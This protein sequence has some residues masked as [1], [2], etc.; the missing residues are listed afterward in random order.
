MATAPGLDVLQLKRSKQTKYY[1]HIFHAIADLMNYRLFS[2]DYYDGILCDG[3]F[4]IP[5][6]R[7]LEKK[8]NLKKKDLI[9]V[10]CC[11]MD[12]LKTRLKTLQI[13]KENFSILIAPTWG[14]DS[15]L[16]KFGSKLIDNLLNEN[17]NIIIRPHPQSLKVE[18]KLID[19]LVLK[20]KN[21]KNIAWD[22]EID[23]LPTMAK[24]DILISDF[25]GII[26]DW[27]F[28]FEKPFLYSMQEINDEI[29]DYSDLDDFS[30]RKNLIKSLGKE[31]DNNSI[32]N[33]ASLIKNLNQD[34]DFQNKIQ[35][36]KKI[37][38]EKQGE[39]AKNIVD[40]IVQKQK[41]LS[42]DSI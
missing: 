6:I 17:W 36:A 23:N 8:R 31:I 24:S 26:F 28:L 15:L 21:N 25:S 40:F 18:K 14:Q 32:G 16:N 27:V 41:E 38:W 13:K 42:N 30:F 9:P 29:Y 4:Q 20:Y 19:K 37:V 33:I 39:S 2:L 3:S 5:A 34:S 12:F 10:G 1:C 11:Y 35:S 22:F 7:E